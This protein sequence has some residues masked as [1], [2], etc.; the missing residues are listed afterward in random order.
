MQNSVTVIPTP[1]P[2][3][4]TL[5]DVH[6]ARARN[7]GSP[8]YSVSNM[9]LTLCEPELKTIEPKNFELY[10]P[11]KL[12]SSYQQKSQIPRKISLTPQDG[13]SD[14]FCQQFSANIIKSKIR[15]ADV[16]GLRH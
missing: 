13:W 16:F 12:E 7:L 9:T 1:K 4:K 5:L 3:R 11:S 8:L 10:L 14:T 6:L 15:L 2:R